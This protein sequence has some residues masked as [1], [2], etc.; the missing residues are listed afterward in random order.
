ML[1]LLWANGTVVGVLH[2][3]FLSDMNEANT[4]FTILSNSETAIDLHPHPQRSG[5]FSCVFLFQIAVCYFC[6][7]RR[8]HQKLV[9]LC[10]FLAKLIWQLITPKNK[11]NI[12]IFAP[13]LQVANCWNSFTAEVGIFSWKQWLSVGWLGGVVVFLSLSWMLLE[14]LKHGVKYNIQLIDPESFF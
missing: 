3:A 4:H 2:Q 5:W 13:P 1:Q 12:C 14:L 7:L 6:E 10:L 8:F 9:L 11:E